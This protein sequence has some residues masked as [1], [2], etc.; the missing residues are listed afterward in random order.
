[1]I[2]LILL[3]IVNSFVC[4]GFWNACLYVPKKMG[5]NPSRLDCENCFIVIQKEVKGILWFVEKW[6]IGKW[7]YKPVCGCLPCMASLHSTYVYWMFMF[8]S[9]EINVES[10]MMY[11]IYILALSGLNHLIDYFKGE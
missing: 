6:A 4:F 1:M 9:N 10:L 3:L 5:R 7:F 2:D 8:V 11:P